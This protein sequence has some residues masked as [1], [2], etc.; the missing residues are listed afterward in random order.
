MVPFWIKNLRGC[1]LVELLT[2]CVSETATLLWESQGNENDVLPEHGS[3]SNSPGW[4]QA[5]QA[6]EESLELLNLPLYFVR[7]VITPG[8]QQFLE[9]FKKKF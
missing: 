6:A 2:E 3:V 5:R 9:L 1:S 4:P 8:S 7:T